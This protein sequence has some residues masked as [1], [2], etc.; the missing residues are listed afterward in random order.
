MPP[1][2]Q[3]DPVQQF[4]PAAQELSEAER[5]VAL[6]RQGL[7][8][9][10]G[11]QDESGP[12]GAL[13]PPVPSSHDGADSAAGGAPLGGVDNRLASHHL[14]L[15]L[16]SVGSLPLP[17]LATAQSPN[18][19]GVA[20]YGGAPALTSLGMT[21]NIGIVQNGG[22]QIPDA[23]SDER[24]A[25]FHRKLRT[26]PR[27]RAQQMTESQRKKRH[28]EHTRASRSRIDRG[29]E[30]LK[31]VIQKVRPERPVNKKADV[32][33]EAVKLL[34]ESYRLPPTESD[35]EKDEPRESSLSV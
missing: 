12:S 28:N 11:G 31:A 6:S 29:L 10:L 2:L 20:T 18:I 9:E 19:Q 8:E 35:E 22:L 24:R 13:P 7:F 23:L 21:H 14:S 32:L 1:T 26:A 27:L 25:S 15:P 17:A 5:T 16:T 33:Q 3:P 4:Q 34:K 30:R